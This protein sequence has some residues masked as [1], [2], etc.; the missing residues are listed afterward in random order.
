[1]IKYVFCLFIA[2]MIA[3][4][5]ADAKEVGSFSLGEVAADGCGT[6]VHL[7]KTKQVVGFVSIENDDGSLYINLDGVNLKLPPE[8]HETPMGERDLSE[9]KRVSL[10]YAGDKVAVR[11]DMKS[12]GLCGLNPEKKLDSCELV[13]FRGTMVVKKDK[14]TTSYKV[15]VHSGC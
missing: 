3:A 4:H 9:G 12:L 13:D 11:L 10:R 15:I 5:A 14:A 2:L 7:P 6:Y 1:M 8:I